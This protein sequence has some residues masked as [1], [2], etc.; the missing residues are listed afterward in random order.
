MPSSPTSSPPP[1]PLTTVG[2]NPSQIRVSDVPLGRGSFGS[3][4]RGT[5]AGSPVAV[6]VCHSSHRNALNNSM[7]RSAAIQFH[8]ETNRYQRLRHPCI[9]QFF[10]VVEDPSEHRLLLVTELMSGGSL[11]D[12]ISKLREASIA[13]LP[14]CS[15]LRIAQH[16]TSGLAYLHAFGFSF[17]DLKS[18]NI[19]LSE[20]PDLQQGTFSSTTQ[21]KL[22]DFGLSRNLRHLMGNKDNSASRGFDPSQTSTP[23]PNGPAG[24]FAY[25][26]PE[27]FSGISTEDA[28]APK[29]ADIYALA[30]VLW[31]LA[32]LDRPWSGKQP[33]Q[34]IRLVRKEAQ[35][36]TW[37]KVLRGLPQG[38]VQLVEQCW[39]QDPLQRPTVEQVA[40]KLQQM[41]EQLPSDAKLSGFPSP[42]K[43]ST[44][45]H[46][47]IFISRATNS[48]ERRD[49]E[50]DDILADE[51][52]AIPVDDGTVVRHVSSRMQGRSL[53]PQRRARIMKQDS[54]YTPEIASK[55][56]ISALETF[57]ED[58]D[59]QLSVIK[60]VETMQP[61]AA[62]VSIP[63]LRI[64]HSAEEIETNTEEEAS[65]SD[66]T[67]IRQESSTS[68]S[69]A[70]FDSMSRS[71][72]SGYESN[73]NLHRKSN[74][75]NDS[76]RYSESM[77][78]M[79]RQG[80][81]IPSRAS[82]PTL[83]RRDAQTIRDILRK[84]PS[85]PD[86]PPPMPR[87]SQRTEPLPQL[88]P[89]VKNSWSYYASVASDVHS[90]SRS[91]MSTKSKS[92]D[93]VTPSPVRTNSQPF[94]PPHV[95]NQQHLQIPTQVDYRPKPYYPVSMTNSHPTDDMSTANT[96][97]Y[98]PNDPEYHTPTLH[99]QQFRQPSFPPASARE[100]Q[101]GNEPRSGPVNLSMSLYPSPSRKG[102]EW[103]SHGQLGSRALRRPD[104][105]PPRP[106]YPAPT[107]RRGGSLDCFVGER[108]RN[109]DEFVRELRRNDTH[110]SCDSLAGRS[111]RAACGLPLRP[112]SE[113]GTRIRHYNVPE[114]GDTSDELKELEADAD[115]SV[116][117][118]SVGVHM[119]TRPHFR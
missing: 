104:Y 62:E 18:M 23:I 107:H 103:P 38:Y 108:S 99:E 59:I 54:F 102:M 43:S 69:G 50:E 91:N 77:V 83:H 40:E 71:E 93:S 87:H 73:S 105:P 41:I 117:F 116:N 26:A 15:L 8:R 30:I 58:D 48:E 42:T 79:T 47:S 64:D 89:P 86:Y 46:D 5:F 82:A 75:R 100:W 98:Y 20:P 39:H 34:L 111:L 55:K 9:T 6:K 17:G 33:L 44:L 68:Q 90:R 67:I 28:D 110:L 16:I 37:P 21:A 112:L 13:R 36:P 10:C 4:W 101:L 72:N 1:S 106:N 12:A 32:T 45:R 19:L 57:P 119:Y 81:V 97:S 88:T 115:G 60:H 76:R 114:E 80:S 51:F 11:Y 31:E 52:D 49:S 113:D 78:A 35:R 61:L 14:P 7:Q 24:T 22:C 53:S 2:V 65:M 3:V 25:L 84:S 63:K 66:V 94:Y 109:E 29:Q 85:R 56:D 70:S 74:S 95:A 96:G 118:S 92:S 27:A